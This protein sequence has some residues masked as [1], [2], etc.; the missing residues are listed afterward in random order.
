MFE[1]RAF[2]LSVQVLGWAV[3]AF[4]VFPVLLTILV[5]FNGSF[6]NSQR[7]V[8]QYVESAYKS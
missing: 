8:L 1:D 6:F 3:I 7:M 2:R 5:S 4:L